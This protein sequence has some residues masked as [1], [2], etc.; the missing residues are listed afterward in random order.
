MFERLK[1]DQELSE[2]EMIDVKSSGDAAIR[3]IDTN[4]ITGK[5]TSMESVEGVCSHRISTFPCIRQPLN[6]PFGSQVPTVDDPPVIV[7]HKELEDRQPQKEKKKK[8]KS[9]GAR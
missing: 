3:G 7:S 4:E 9:E 5:H 2:W 6:L 1:S 8:K